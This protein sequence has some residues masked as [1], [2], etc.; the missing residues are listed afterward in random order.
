MS[1]AVKI[2]VHYVVAGCDG[3]LQP[4]ARRDANMPEGTSVEALVADHIDKNM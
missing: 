3:T 2:A 1:S 4:L